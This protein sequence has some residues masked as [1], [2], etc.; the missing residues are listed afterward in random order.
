MPLTT[1][2]VAYLNGVEQELS[3][4]LSSE[5]ASNGA[6]Y[7]DTY[8]PSIGHDA[9]KSLSVRVFSFVGYAD[10]LPYRRTEGQKIDTSPRSGR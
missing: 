5:A 6:A 3:S 1:G 10:G 9:C 7:V 2:D 4:M 8:T